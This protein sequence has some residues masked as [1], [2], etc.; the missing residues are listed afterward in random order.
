MKLFRGFPVL[1]A[2]LALCACSTLD[3]ASG[4]ASAGA[5]IADA[6]GAAAPVSYADHTTLDETTMQLAETA[7]KLSAIAVELGVD[8]GVIKGTRAAWFKS[9]DSRAFLALATVRSAYRAGNAASFRAAYAE[10]K[11][12]LGQVTAQL[13]PS[14]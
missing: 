3:T 8:V 13:K 6:S 9:M 10:L 1:I 14:Q 7:Y 4:V 11:T 5:T 2:A 12:L